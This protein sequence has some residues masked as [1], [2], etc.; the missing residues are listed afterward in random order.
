[1]LGLEIVGLDEAARVLDDAGVHLL[2]RTEA[3]LLPVPAETGEVPLALIE[4]PLW[5]G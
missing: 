3:M 2:R 5:R 4:R 1:V